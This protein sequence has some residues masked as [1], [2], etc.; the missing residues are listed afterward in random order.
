[1]LSIINYVNGACNKHV[2]NVILKQGIQF[3]FGSKAT[4]YRHG[5]EKDRTCILVAIPEL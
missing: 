2:L 4:V 5:K 3:T 1:M